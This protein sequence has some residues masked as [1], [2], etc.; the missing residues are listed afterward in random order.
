[1]VDVAAA[2]QAYHIAIFSHIGLI[3]SVYYLADG[4]T[5]VG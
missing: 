2:G 5:K 3:K 4:L 1:M